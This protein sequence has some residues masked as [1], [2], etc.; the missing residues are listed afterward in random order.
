MRDGYREL[1]VTVVEKLF[2]RGL[3][4]V[5]TAFGYSCPSGVNDPQETEAELPRKERSLLCQAFVSL[6]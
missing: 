4:H 1:T 2:L 6:S 3:P 5:R